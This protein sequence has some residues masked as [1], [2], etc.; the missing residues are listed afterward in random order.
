MMTL[1]TLFCAGFV[2]SGLV[3]SYHFDLPSGP[4]IIVIAGAF[5]LL[6]VL[7]SRFIVK[8]SSSA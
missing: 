3:V 8:K 7:G 1:A 5:Y 2:G 4:V 6:V